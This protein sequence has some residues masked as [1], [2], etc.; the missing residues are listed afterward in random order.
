MKRILITLLAATL[1]FATV[2]PRPASALSEDEKKALAIAL[3]LGLGIA[4]AKH[5]K[6]HNSSTDWDEGL[7][8]QPFSPGQ[9]VLCMPKQRKCYVN[10][11]L[12]YRWTRRI[13]G[14]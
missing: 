12:S 14:A 6:T 2:A 7:Y 5:G 10:G 9:N 4:A 8:G 1:V 3:A 13:F 11:H